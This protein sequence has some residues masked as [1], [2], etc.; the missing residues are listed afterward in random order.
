MLIERLP[1]RRC[2]LGPGVDLQRREARGDHGAGSVGVAGLACEFDTAPGEGFRAQLQ[3]RAGDA[4][5]GT[6]AP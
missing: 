1:A 5:S 2:I 4:A 3:L 6:D